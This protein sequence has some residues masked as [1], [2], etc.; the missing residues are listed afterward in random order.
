MIHGRN[1]LSFSFV[2]RRLVLE[3][4]CTRVSFVLQASS[5]LGGSEIDFLE[6]FAVRSPKKSSRNNENLKFFCLSASRDDTEIA[7]TIKKIKVEGSEINLIYDSFLI[8]S[9]IMFTEQQ[10]KRNCLAVTGFSLQ[11]LE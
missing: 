4:T 2:S 9:E 5:S 7:I 8:S 10:L 11:F 3:I 6:E 1:N